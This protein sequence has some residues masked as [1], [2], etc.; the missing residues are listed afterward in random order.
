LAVDFA[1]IKIYPCSTVQGLTRI[2]LL[3][4]RNPC[5]HLLFMLFKPYRDKIY[6]S[7]SPHFLHSVTDQP[8]PANLE[9]AGHFAK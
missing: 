7:L 1:F 5:W 8:L 3:A 2:A 9:Q 4:G 6:D